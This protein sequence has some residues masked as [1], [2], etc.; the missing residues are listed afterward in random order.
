MTIEENVQRITEAKADIRSAIAEKG[1]EVSSEEKIDGYANLIRQI[2]T[3]GSGES[4][5]FTKDWILIYTLRGTSNKRIRFS[6][7]EYQ[8]KVEEY[9]INNGLFK[10][11]ITIIETTEGFKEDEE[12]DFS[13]M[14]RLRY[15]QVGEMTIYK[16]NDNLTEYIL[17]T[18]YQFA[19]MTSPGK[20]FVQ[21]QISFYHYSD[22]LLDDW[23]IQENVKELS[24]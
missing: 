3:G 9:I 1:V 5:M 22:G 18:P 20:Y 6:S 13:K 4:E 24:L 8:K 19:S 11:N 2:P 21:R 17:Y 10:G 16:V 7:E 12:I 23:R 15:Y 14:V